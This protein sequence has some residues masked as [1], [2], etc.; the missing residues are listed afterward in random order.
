LERL[1]RRQQ[2]L[3]KRPK[4]QVV[5]RRNFQVGKG[6]GKGGKVKCVDRRLLKDRRA[7]NAKSKAKVKSGMK[8]KRGK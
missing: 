5:V 7:S 6:G 2:Q 8:R 3:G 1:A 4:K